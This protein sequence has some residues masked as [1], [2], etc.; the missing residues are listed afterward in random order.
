MQR[1]AVSWRRRAASWSIGVVGAVA[2]L[3]IGPAT[4]SA[5]SPCTMR[6]TAQPFSWLGDLNKYFVAPNGTFENSPDGIT[7]PEWTAVG[8][9]RLYS[10][11]QN[12]WLING[13]AH[14]RA[15]WVP[16]GGTLTSGWFCA[17]ADEDSMRFFITP[18]SQQSRIELTMNVSNGVNQISK[19]V[20]L[21]PWSWAD[22]KISKNGWYWNYTPRIMFPDLRDVNG[23][24][25][26]QLKFRVFASD[27]TSVAGT[28]ID[29][30]MVDPWRTN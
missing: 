19:T 16:K 22:Y 24:Q 11:F 29:D 2:A 28:F 5:D 25:W 20:V 1:R 12:P 15:A 27:G 17:N 9:S 10:N 8:G 3:A 21:N 13:T 30:I 7:A 23:Q 26:V 14:N 18:Q 6:T 4:A